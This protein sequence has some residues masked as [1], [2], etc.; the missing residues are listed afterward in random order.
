MAKK[1]FVAC[2]LAICL[3]H[4][5]GCKGGA[6]AAKTSAPSNP[7][8][9]SE[10]GAPSAPEHGADDPEDAPRMLM[11]NGQ[12]YVDAERASEIDGRC[13]MMD[14]SVTSTVKAGERPA[15]DGQSNFGVGY[16]YQYGE[17]ETVEVQIDGTFFV[18][19]RENAN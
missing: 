11:V 12:I 6:D 3:F 7:P 2:L 15:K 16:G 18:F 1:F 5:A 13:G 19:T 4:I 8:A 9:V 17:G 14:G 10:G